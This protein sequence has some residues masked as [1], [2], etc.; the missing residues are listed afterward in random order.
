MN[1]L[2]LPIKAFG[3][4][5]L[6]VVL[7]FIPQ[8][9]QAQS[10][11][12]GTPTPNGFSMLD[13]SSSNKGLLIPRMALTSTTSNA[14]IGAFVAGMMVYN[15]ATTGD[16]TP[17]FYLCNGTKWEKAGGGWGLSG[18]AGT[19]PTTNFI[20]T[21]DDQD[22]VFKRNNERA[23]LLGISNTSFGHN[24]LNPS[25]SGS[26]NTAFG[27]F[28]L[29][30]PG[31][32]NENTAIGHSVLP[33]NTTGSNNTA[34]GSVAM[35]GNTIGNDNIGIGFYALDNNKAGNYGIAIGNYAMKNANSLA[36][37]FSNTNIAIGASALH[38][39]NT[40]ANNTGLANNAIG[41]TAL[42]NNSTGSRN[43]T[44]GTEALY[45]NTT[46]SANIAIGY[47]SLYNNTNKSGN[48]AIG[49]SA[50]YN[51][52]IG[53]TVA[54]DGAFN[55]A[56]GSNA[57]KSNTTGW[58]GTA[59]GYKAL[60]KNT[61]GRFNTAVGHL[62]LSE[63]V[64]GGGNAAFGQGALLKSNGIG[65][66]SA[67]G[68]RS[69]ENLTTGSYNLAMGWRA[70]FFNSLGSRNI[71]I[72]S[73]A[74]YNEAGSDRLYIE[75]SNA[76]ANNALIYGEFDTDKLRINNKLGIGLNSA[77][78]PLEV[79]AINVGINN[80][81]LVKFY[82]SGGVAKWHLSLTSNQLNFVESGVATDRLVIRPGGNVTIGGPMAAGHKL[83]VDGKIACTEVRVQPT[84]A[85]PD[86]VFSPDYN[87]MPLK[88][89]ENSINSQKHLPG[90]PS[91][92]EIEIDGIQVGEMQ[93]KMMEKIEELTLYIIDLNKKVES[94]QSENNRQADQIK[95]LSNK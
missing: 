23:G 86:Y 68:N 72:G 12:I 1:N 18:N 44:L 24:A 43:N 35:F 82:T 77:S 57:M 55:T 41:F 5:A 13:I 94:L 61:T 64:S 38:G 75:S 88:E 70:G 32:S 7:T 73:E 67:F 74:G 6:F 51:N 17:G 65:G 71:F 85:W 79:K 95:T 2:K 78:F 80:E 3:L 8:L 60:M 81:D 25:N 4:S 54:D 36:T 16:V 92:K 69:L 87:L 59:V 58:W 22:F 10:V 90:I 14:P 89:L 34:L 52:G 63:N 39:S 15:T 45:Y 84:S 11:G 91:A 27:K 48:T 49:D 83:S 66:N 37:P 29:V 19:S 93:R 28:A 26:N 20:G 46:G 42:Y 30:A 56:I 53:A 76:D 47:R 21:T 40:P 9:I 31:I 50:L 62:A 33:N